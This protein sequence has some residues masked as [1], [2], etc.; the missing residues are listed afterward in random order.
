M[1][2]LA[3]SLDDI[4]SDEEIE[5]LLASAADEGDEFAASMIDLVH[6]IKVNAVSTQFK[7]GCHTVEHPGSLTI[8]AKKSSFTS[9]EILSFLL[10]RFGITNNEIINICW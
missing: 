5:L 9:R 1:T 6:E 8:T 10:L 7:G 3:V 4:P 2:Y